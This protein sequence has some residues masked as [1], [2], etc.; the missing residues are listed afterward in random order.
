MVT[1]QAGWFFG[2]RVP[3]VIY[4]SIDDFFG[5]YLKFSLLVTISVDA[6]VLQRTK[7]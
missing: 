4:D 5:K 2:K 1:G 6:D 3:G 7:S